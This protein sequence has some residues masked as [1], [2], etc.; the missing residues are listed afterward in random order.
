MI[1]LAMALQLVSAGLRVPVVYDHVP[2]DVIRVE[3]YVWT[4]DRPAGREDVVYGSRRITV[5]GRPRGL[6]VAALFRTDGR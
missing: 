5:N 2:P 3:L 1:A 4:G 6:Y